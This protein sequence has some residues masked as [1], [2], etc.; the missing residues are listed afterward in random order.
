MFARVRI[1]ILPSTNSNSAYFIKLYS[2]AI[3]FMG[4]KGRSPF[5]IDIYGNQ[6]EH[7]HRRHCQSGLPGKQTTQLLV[8]QIA[9]YQS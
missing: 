4:K 5:L 7:S 9:H 8:V 2:S 6:Q 1:G 3:C